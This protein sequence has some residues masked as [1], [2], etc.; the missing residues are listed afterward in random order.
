MSD[1]EIDKEIEKTLDDIFEDI[2]EEL[3]EIKK[4]AEKDK[5][6]GKKKRT[7]KEIYQDR[8]PE[9]KEQINNVIKDSEVAIICVGDGGMMSSGTGKDILAL[10]S[11][12]F[13][14]IIKDREIPREK[15]KW[16]FEKILEHS[17]DD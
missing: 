4:E 11:S 10:L 5:K 1:R 15:M 12:A 9:I 7:D 6:E 8:L 16:I 17:Y 14:E 3:K 13:E 2:L